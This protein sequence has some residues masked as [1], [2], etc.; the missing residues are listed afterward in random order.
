MGC[1]AERTWSRIAVHSKGVA[2][3][4]WFLKLV[5]VQIVIYLA[6]AWLSLRTRDSRLLLVLGLIF[7]ALF[8]LSIDFSAPYLSDDIYRYVWDGRVQSAGINPYRYI[9]ADEALAQLRDEK[10]YPNINR[11]DSAHTIYPPVAEGAFLLITRFSESVTWMKA[12]MVGFEAIA[13]WA[14]VQLLISLG[15]ARQRV[16]IYAWHPL[17]VWELAGSGHVDA[18]AIAFIAAA[19]L[20]HRRRR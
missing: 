10:I 20:A 17:V 7:A 1:D 16:L 19:L 12:A 2:D 14:L 13:V 9:P 6:A 8:R 5:V 15:F 11:R 18:L 3:I 4:L